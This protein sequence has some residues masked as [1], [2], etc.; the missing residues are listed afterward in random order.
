MAW[1]LLA[2]PFMVNAQNHKVIKGPYL[3]WSRDPR[4]TMTVSWETEDKFAGKVVYGLTR[5]KMGT[6]TK[7]YSEAAVHQV[8]LTGLK[9]DTRYYYQLANSEAVPCSFRTA[10]AGVRPFK[11]AI[12]G[13]TRSHPEKHAGV[14]AA[15]NNYGPELVINT[16]DLVWDGRLWELWDDF[17]KA[18]GP[19]ADH[20][21]YLSAIGNHERTASNYL[22]FFGFPGNEQWYSFDYADA[23]FT[24]LNTNEDFGPG[25]PQYLWL[26]DDLQKSQRSAAWR[27]VVMHHPA[28]SAGRYGPNQEVID[29]LVPLFRKYGVQAVFTGHDHNYQHHRQQGIHYIITGGGGAPLY[30]IKGGD[31]LLYG[32]TSLHYLQLE[33]DSELLKIR[34]VR[35][36]GSVPDSMVLKADK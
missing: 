5:D 7:E 28:Y 33:V 26:Q 36:D 9:P 30:D 31:S 15:I 19:L 34:M 24:V 35:M 10:P 18:I 20:V 16:G 6:E 32:E 23:H 29:R 21:P 14:A 11:M 27:L 4:T 8:T 1:A 2:T 25:S 17:F 3:S 22:L 13:D 12:Y